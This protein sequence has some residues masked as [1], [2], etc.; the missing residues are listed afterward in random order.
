MLYNFHMI[1]ILLI[2]YFGK[3]KIQYR[4]FDWR[5]A[6]SEHFKIFYYGGGEH[7]KDF[8]ISVLE[9]AYEEYKTLMPRIPK[10]RIPVIIYNSAEDF[11]QTNVIFDIID[12]GVGGFTEVFKNRIVVPFFNSYEDFKH[13]LKHELV[14]A[15]QYEALST[16]GSLLS[17]VARIPLWVMEGMAEYVSIGWDISGETYVRDLVLNDLLLPINVLNYYGGYIVYKQGQAIFYYIEREYSKEKLKEFISNVLMMYDLNSAIKRTFGIEIDEFSRK[18]NIF[19]K[20]LYYPTLR[21]FNLPSNVIR[22]TNNKKGQGY[23]NIAPAIDPNASKVIFISDRNDYSDIYIS[24]ITGSYQKKI[25]S[26]QT[27]PD[28]ENL[29]L[30]SAKISFSDDGNYFT[31]V[32]RGKGYDIIYISDLNGKIKRKIEIKT[33][34]GINYPSFSKDNNSIVFIGLKDGKQDIYLYNSKNSTLRRLTN[35]YFNELFPIFS[36]DGNIYFIS[37]RNENSFKFGNYAV[38]KYNLENDSIYQI[39]P[40]LGKIYYFDLRND[41]PVVALEYKGTI[42]VFEYNN[43]KL[44]KLTNFPSAV[45][46]FSFDKSGEKMVINLQYE[47]A[48]EIFYIPEVRILDSIELKMGE[49]SEYKLFD[50]KNYKYRTELSLSWL[51]GVALGSSFGIGGYITLGFSD[52]TGDNWIILQTQSY[53]QDIT[54]AI[55]FLDYLY[56]K[57][58][59]DLDLSSYQYWSISYLRQFDKFSYDKILGGSFL[60]YYPFNRFDRI[61]FGFTYNYYTRYLGNFTI[62]GFLYDTILYKNA[63]NGYLAFSRDKILYYPWGPVDGHGFFIAF[64]PSLLLSQ[65]KNNIIY[66]DLRYYFRFA[67]RYIL[68]FRTIGY[69]SFGEDKEGIILYGPDL[70]RG[71]TLDTILVG[72]NSFVSNLEFRFP[73]I[74]YLKLGFPIPLTISSVRG[75]IFYDIGSAWFDNEKFKFIENDSLS[76]PKSSFGFNISIFLGFG[77]IYFNWAW[78]T[79]LKYTDSNPRFNIYF[80]LDY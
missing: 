43:D 40:Y 76:T 71:W 68:A 49:F 44:Y 26:G 72:N 27:K 16:K 14:H 33:L 36:S 24:T 9:E 11:R 4:D 38:F 61:E 78:R 34:D 41:K 19:L 46:S 18:F 3:N 7:L 79:N 60:I 56:L 59:W 5:V 10:D 48:R 21:D 77:N 70:I 58:R 13:V 8:A 63:L 22:I 52:W 67:K 54:N 17:N 28:L 65:I 2:T 66:G 45:Y 64:Q 23:F 73:F 1:E 51:S 55:F 80:G 37:D 25:I 42:N 62:F 75:S 39:T 6:Q 12:E 31:F 30:L 50:Y 29:H 20:E 47:G 57:K 32:A 74:E 69:K 53:I 35:D 15:F